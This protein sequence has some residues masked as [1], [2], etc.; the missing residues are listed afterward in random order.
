MTKHPTTTV[1]GDIGRRIAMRREELG[2]S[3]EDVAAHAGIDPGYLRYVERDSTAAPGIATLHALA[4][5]L[6]TSVSALSGGEADLPPGRGQA[7]GRA[8]LVELGAEEC[9][10]LLSTHGVGR[11]ALSMPEGLTVLPVNYCVVDG[12]IAFRTAAAATPTEASDTKCA[13]EVDEVDDALSQGWSVLVR[14]MAH[15]VTDPTGVR[16]LDEQ[17]YSGPWA[18]GDR[19]LW[20]RITPASVTG[21][22]IVVG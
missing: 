18:G 5:T 3:P 8:R 13:F 4:M 15:T 6:N 22:R 10:Q 11:I 12:G 19:D 20:V 2:L 14:G 21:R 1:A 16:R 7:A 9:W 17:A